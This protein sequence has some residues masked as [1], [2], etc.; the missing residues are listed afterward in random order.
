MV[1]FLNLNRHFE[2]GK[3]LSLR[4]KVRGCVENGRI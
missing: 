2:N 3:M 4:G 1:N